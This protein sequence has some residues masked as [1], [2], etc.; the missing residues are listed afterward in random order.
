MIEDALFDS[1]A[2]E[3]VEPPAPE[4]MDDNYEEHEYYDEKGKVKAGI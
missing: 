4:K 1:E 2:I 3:E